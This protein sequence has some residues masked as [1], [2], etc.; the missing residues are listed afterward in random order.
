MTLPELIQSAIDTAVAGT[1]PN[2]N[3]LQFLRMEAETLSEQAFHE[4]ATKCASDPE[5]RGRL[6]KSFSVALTSGSATLPAGILVEYL[7]EGSVRDG[8]TGANNGQG[9]VL[10]R[11]K[12]YDDLVKS[13][14]AVF[15]YYCIENNKIFTRNISD[16]DLTATLSPLTVYAPFVPTKADV[17]TE[18]PDEIVDEMVVML[19]TRLRGLI[20]EQAA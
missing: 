8:D 18:V 12:Y 10:V 19:A 11:V 1:N 5:L 2:T 17:D 3:V 20:A 6:S 15:G 14:P 16:G 4:L 13:L 9:N 7:R